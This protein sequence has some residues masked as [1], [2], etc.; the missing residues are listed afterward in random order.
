MRRAARDLGG[1]ASG[2]RICMRVEQHECGDHSAAGVL[3][4]A[5]LGVEPVELIIELLNSSMKC[6]ALAVLLAVFVTG[7]TESFTGKLV[8]RCAAICKQ[9]DKSRGTL[10]LKDITD[11][12]WTKMYVFPGWT[13]S[14]TISRITGVKYA[15]SDVPDDYRR[16]IFFNGDKEV[17]E[18]DFIPFDY[19]HSTI[20]FSGFE[21]YPFCTPEH[22]LFEI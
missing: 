10:N 8:D 20:N 17:Y 15:K 9:N 21:S 11:F 3:V 13:T 1:D 2:F 12:S 19:Y 4:C 22:S 7:C 5:F 14:D 18:E 16:M 6:T